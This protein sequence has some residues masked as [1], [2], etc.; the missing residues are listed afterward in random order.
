[1][2][3][4]AALA[5]LLGLVLLFMALG[6]PVAIAFLA[7]NMVGA[8]VFMGGAGDLFERAS[9]GIGQL[10]ANAAAA[11]TS[12]SL[13]PVPMFLLM[14]EL[15]FHTGQ[16]ERLFGAIER[17]MGRVPGRLSYVAVA[18]GT[19]FA[20]LSGSS[21]GST[22]LLGSLMTPEMSRRGYKTHMAIG[23]IL[24]AGG[25]AMLIPPSALAVLLAT[26][27]QLDVGG[28]LLAGVGPGLA[29]AALYA[30]LIFVQCRLDPAAAPAGEADPEARRGRLRA[31][32]ADIAPPMAVMAGVIALILGGWA[33]PSESAAFGCLGV[34][35][36]AAARGAL[37]WSAIRRAA[38][39]ALRVSAMSLLIIFGSAT[40][41]KL[42]AFSGASGGLID[43][44]AGFAMPPHAMLLV[45]FGILLI[46]GMF[47][48]QLSMMLL[49]VPVFFPLA[50]A[51]GF[52]PVWFGA[53]V[54]IALEIGFATPPFGLL[55]FVMKG[56]A[57]PGTS[58]RD[59][60]V[61]AL[62][63]VGCALLVAGLLAAAPQL[64]L[65]LPG[66]AGR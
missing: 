3:W 4:P 22:A 14:G 20:S 2:E 32:A 21:M 51:Q 43:W 45:M 5:L 42:L 66:L 47:M 41:A 52:D 25:L 61:A 31:A 64:A 44:A 50:A 49:T 60:Y 63:Y 11:V 55:L 56:V 12:F 17:L 9:R 38:F 39:G 16:A 36:L 23:P 28:L 54:L 18:G 6:A 7:A 65:W 46:L 59:I 15:F 53:M 35:A 34:A 13:I 37:G 10:A 29:L 24:G 30:L 1:M 19:A 26:L 62:P 8:V 48:D 27:A 33:T 40:F 57:P 58:M